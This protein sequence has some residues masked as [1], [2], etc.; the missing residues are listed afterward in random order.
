MSMS[1]AARFKNFM[2]TMERSDINTGFLNEVI[3]GPDTIWGQHVLFIDNQ[4]NNEI[5]AT[6]IETSPPALSLLVSFSDASFMLLTVNAEGKGRNYV[7]DS[8]SCDLAKVITDLTK[9]SEKMAN[10]MKIVGNDDFDQEEAIDA[11]AEV[12]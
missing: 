12:I 7:I 2:Q 5:L 4:L 1:T 6:C 9:I 8:D 10:V 11:M 3:G